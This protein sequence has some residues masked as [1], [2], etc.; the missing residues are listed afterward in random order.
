MRLQV[1]CITA[2]MRATA[3][4]VVEIVSRL[5]GYATET[6]LAYGGPSFDGHDAARAWP[7]A[8]SI[9][10]RQWKGRSG[11]L[12]T[13]PRRRKGGAN[14]STLTNKPHQDVLA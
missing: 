8:P 7:Q 11:G 13:C 5:A 4:Q 6:A 1:L 10:V 9:S 12:N 2:T 3:D 14:S